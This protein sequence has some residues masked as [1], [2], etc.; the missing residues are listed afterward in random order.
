VLY[1]VF[2]DEDQWRFLG[3][4][5]M[6]SRY[7]GDKCVMHCIAMQCTSFPFSLG[8]HSGS[9]TILLL[10]PPITAIAILHILVIIFIFTFTAIDAVPARLRFLF[11]IRITHSI[12]FIFIFILALAIESVLGL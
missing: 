6:V 10:T 7:I 5:V 2:E 3:A 11:G 1:V 4:L 8:P 12:I 9:S